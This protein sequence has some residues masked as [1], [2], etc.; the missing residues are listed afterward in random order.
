MNLRI[1]TSVL[2]GF[3][4]TSVNNIYAQD[5]FE[6]WLKKDSEEFNKFLSE[7]DKEFLNFLKNN[8]SEFK[9]NDAKKTDEKPKPK[10]PPVFVSETEDVN[11]QTPV[12]KPKAE[13]TKP[14]PEA[15]QKSPENLPKPDKLPAEPEIEKKDIPSPPEP[16]KTIPKP[17]AGIEKEKEKLIIEKPKLNPADYCRITF[18][19][20]DVVLPKL[21]KLSPFNSSGITNELIQDYWVKLSNSGYVDV[22]K[23]AGEIKR[24]LQ[25]NDWGYYLL[26]HD[27]IVETF[28]NDKNSQSLLLWFL[29][30]KSGYKARIVRTEKEI[31]LAIPSRSVFFGTPYVNG[32]EENEKSY[33]VTVDKKDGIPNQFYSYKKDHPEARNYIDLTID[34]SPLFIS[35]PES[36]ELK[37]D[38]Q[39]T[40]FSASVNYDLGAVKFFEH[41]PLTELNTYFNAALSEK[42]Q[43]SLL[44]SLSSI[45]KDKPEPVAAN[46]ILRFVQTAFEYET[47]QQNF[48]REKPMFKEEIVHYKHS[49]CEDRSILFSY[50]IKELLGLK[51]IGVDYPGH[52][53]T[54]VKFNSP[55][56]G[57]YILYENEKYTICDP[58]YIG[59]YIGMCMPEYKN[60]K[61]ENIIKIK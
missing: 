59:A 33:L 1:F 12:K 9:L 58:T 48:G 43:R 39:G 16:V 32:A 35:S 25:L 29:L 20:E 27:I 52:V 15:E 8:W 21:K 2:V 7:E 61:Y 46:M 51:V 31:Y 11:P 57:D 36:K 4:L 55:M 22:L 49:D 53:C 26:L 17:H 3:I 37:F 56:E 24:E 5:D 47:D 40:Q 13:N 23:R 30:N 10:K 42:I 6:K 38:Y 14:L 44:K 45:I 41:Y 50:L 19:N 60:Q 54:A 28:K 18:Y 34:R